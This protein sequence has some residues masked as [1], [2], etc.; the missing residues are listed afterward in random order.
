MELQGRGLLGPLLTCELQDRHLLRAAGSTFADTC[1][2]A[3]Q[4][5]AGIC[6]RL[7]VFAPRPRL[8]AMMVS[9]QVYI[10]VYKKEK[11]ILLVA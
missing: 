5:R 10:L 3:S 4:W 1:V 9:L 8:R 11:F 7:Y 2:N 6:I